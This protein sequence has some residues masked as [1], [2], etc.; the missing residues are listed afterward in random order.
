VSSPSGTQSAP[1]GELRERLLNIYA[2]TKTIAVVG[3]SADESKPAGS[4][5]LC[6]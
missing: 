2:R 5:W 3:A 4:P 6:R 1:Q